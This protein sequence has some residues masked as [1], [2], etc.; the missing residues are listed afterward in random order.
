MIAIFSNIAIIPLHRANLVQRESLGS[1][2]LME[3]P[4]K[5]VHKGLLD[6]REYKGA[7]VQGDLSDRK[8][9]R[10][11]RDLKEYLGHKDHEEILVMWDRRLVHTL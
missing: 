10:E 8:D 1:Q 2:D 3:F 7:M 4:A 6:Q 5:Q 9:Q 11:P